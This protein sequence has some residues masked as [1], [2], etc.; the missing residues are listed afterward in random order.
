M[1][2]QAQD[3][4]A[5][6]PGLTKHIPPEELAAEATSLEEG[7]IPI[8]SYPS[9]D[10]FL[11]GNVMSLGG[12]SVAK[13]M[14][15]DTQKNTA[16]LIKKYN[17]ARKYGNRNPRLAAEADNMFYALDAIYQDGLLVDVTQNQ[18]QMIAFKGGDPNKTIGTVIS[19]VHPFNK[20]K[21]G[22]YAPEGSLLYDYA[23]DRLSIHGYMQPIVDKLLDDSAGASLGA[24]E[25]DLYDKDLINLSL[26]HI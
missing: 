4:F 9:F 23:S 24:E 20:T 7:A 13:Y 1:P 25:L 2:T 21:T 5:N 3:I 11:T 15:G 19:G 14:D 10:E 6:V 12:T 22:I 26:I 16:E 8:E 18:K 17:H